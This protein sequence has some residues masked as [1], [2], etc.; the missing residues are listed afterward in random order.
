M[1]NKILSYKLGLV[2]FLLTSS[3]CI[4]AVEVSGYG[5]I[6]FGQALKGSDFL[7]ESTDRN[8]ITTQNK[9]SYEIYNDTL[10]FKNATRFGLQLS[11]SWDDT[12]SITA[13]ILS[14]GN[15][16]E[17]FQPEVTWMF[18]KK[19]FTPNTSVTVGRFS[20][21]FYY[22]SE[23]IDVG[24][25]YNWIRPPADAYRI[26][27]KSMNG[28]KVTHDLQVGNGYL[29]AD[30]FYGDAEQRAV[31]ANSILGGSLNY[32]YDWLTVR[33]QH[34]KWNVDWLIGGDNAATDVDA[35]YSSL[36]IMLDKNDFLLSSEYMKVELPD[37]RLTVAPTIAKDVQQT[38]YYVTLGYRINSITPYINYTNY[39]RVVKAPDTV[40]S[41]TDSYN[42]GVRWDTPGGLAIKLE[43]IQQKQDGISTNNVNAIAGSIDF[44]F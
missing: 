41:T 35:S 13:Q 10:S 11:H 15:T 39:E 25:A 9:P 34:S 5:S 20:T 3:V 29:T 40:P 18:L 37:K 28:V 33:L 30:V 21:P 4:H 36:A 24:Y 8:G 12:L 19:Q 32:S 14:D 6:G 23:S 31:K 44:I 27:M 26:D 38:S 42:Y 1:K 17:A 2:T 43:Y 22:F 7:D 16:E